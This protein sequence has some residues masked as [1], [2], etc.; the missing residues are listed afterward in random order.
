MYTRHTLLILVLFKDFHS[1]HYREFLQDV[2]DMEGV[3]EI[4][5]LSV[6]PHFT[7]L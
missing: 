7:I 3:L 1:Q 6:V 2:G 5:D 4:L